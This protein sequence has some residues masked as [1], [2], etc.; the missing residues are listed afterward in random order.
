M[1]RKIEYTVCG[2]S[3]EGRKLAARKKEGVGK[4]MHVVRFKWKWLNLKPNKRKEWTK[5]MNKCKRD[6]Y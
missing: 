3:G 6:I 2:W 4:K 5:P 1:T